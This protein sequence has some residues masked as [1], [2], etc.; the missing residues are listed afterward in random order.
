[1]MCFLDK[2]FC[3]QKCGN[4]ECERNLTPEREKQAQT[5]WGG[6]DVPI[7]LCD[8]RDVQPY[9]IGFKEINDT[10]RPNASQD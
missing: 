8:F 3:S 1:M 7:A 6:E 9:C 5:W 4:L 10:P 2:T